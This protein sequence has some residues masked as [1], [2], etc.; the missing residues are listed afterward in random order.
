MPKKY[1]ITSKIF[2]TYYVLTYL[3]I[4]DNYAY[5][6][7]REAFSRS[8]DRSGNSIYAPSESSIY[9]LLNRLEINGYV[10]SIIKNDSQTSKPRKYFSINQKGIDYL[11][12]LSITFSERKIIDII[13]PEL[14]VKTEIK[15]NEN[16]SQNLI[17]QTPIVDNSINNDTTLNNVSS[18]TRS[19]IF[20]NVFNNINYGNSTNNEI[21][22]NNVLKIENN[23]NFELN[24]NVNVLYESSFQ[25][26]LGKSFDEN[27][28][29]TS[30]NKKRNSFVNT[31]NKSFQNISN[32]N[33]FDFPINGNVNSAEFN[34]IDGNVEDV[35]FDN[36]CLNIFEDILVCESNNE[37]II[38]TEEDNVE[39][40]SNEYI[41]PSSTPIN[42]N[43]ENRFQHPDFCYEINENLTYETNDTIFQLENET[44]THAQKINQFQT[45]N[46]Q[47]QI[48]TDEEF[49][50]T[51]REKKKNNQSKLIIK[52]FNN[53][54]KINTLTNYYNINLSNLLVSSF[55]SMVIAIE[56]IVFFSLNIITDNLY[57]L[58][59]LDITVAQLLF[60]IIRYMLNKQLK[61]E[62]CNDFG[63]NLLIFV[64]L[65]ILTVLIYIFITL[66]LK[67]SLNLNY[68]LEYIIPLTL[69]IAILILIPFINLFIV[70]LMTRKE[71]LNG[72]MRTKC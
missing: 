44:E 46:I 57:Y 58:I 64:L 61:K 34:D 36:E 49:Y 13:F 63:K 11:K 3:S 54:Y 50:E 8:R 22:N 53:A 33:E 67:K 7:R 55:F 41:K 10:T 65:S 27:D 23:K 42:T 1:V 19:E 29:I 25:E 70:N 31:Q 21:D 47:N 52:N 24:N 28:F 45:Q 6:I 48:N 26:S 37:N 60:F 17:I 62:K 12:T 71:K 68:I 43:F 9:T 15:K 72:N 39:I 35:N 69:N 5:D 40:I 14:K 2:N 51:K 38:K 30:L 66:I 59:C 20:N 56:L 16:L 4:K 32:N 18:N